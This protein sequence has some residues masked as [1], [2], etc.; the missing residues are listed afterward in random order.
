MT[1]PVPLD[2]GP[3]VSFLSAEQEHSDWIVAQWKRLRPPLLTCEPVL[4]ETAYPGWVAEV[5]GEP[6]EIRAA[7]DA[8]LAVAVESDATRLQ[9]RYRPRILLGSLVAFP[10]V[11]LLWLIWFA[12]SG[13][14]VGR[15]RPS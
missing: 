7:A 3:L 6:A 1:G 10:L 11:W 4:T 9:C 14:R 13:V 8:L 12:M 5:D 15:R 2:T